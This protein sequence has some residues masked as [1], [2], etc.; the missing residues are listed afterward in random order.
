MKYRFLVLGSDLRQ[1]Y[2]Y[3]LLQSKEYEARIIADIE[4]CN[5]TAVEDFDVILL[6]VSGSGSIYRRIKDFLQPGQIVCGVHILGNE[7]K[8]T[9]VT[10]I[11][12]MDSDA[13]AY[14]NAVATAEGTIALAITMSPVN[15]A[16]SQCLVAG[17]GRC[18]EVLCEKLKGLGGL[19][20]VV[21]RS[22]NRRACARAHGIDALDFA[23]LDQNVER[24]S[25]YSYIFNTVP[26]MVFPE[27]ILCHTKDDVV[28][29]DIASGNGGV[30]FKFC[31]KNG[32]CTKHALGIPGIYAPKTS[33]EILYAV[34][35]DRLTNSNR[36]LEG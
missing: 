18:G 26:A 11:E 13:T 3:E 1:H 15:L 31:E 29:L 35:M 2:L 14:E 6:P 34:L 32:I 19:V 17:Y 24:I 16:G 12:Y 28:I 33:A 5:I 7:L 23:Q 30:D 27:K 8:F 25:T 21:E 4:Q 22:A 36:R 20:T 9:G 10:Y